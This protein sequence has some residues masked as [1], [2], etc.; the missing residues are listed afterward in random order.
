M[1]YGKVISANDEVVVIPKIRKDQ[2]RKCQ[3]IVRANSKFPDIAVGLLRDYLKENPELL[4]IT[5]NK[6]TDTINVT[7]VHQFSRMKTVYTFKLTAP[8][9]LETPTL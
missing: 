3:T 6:E 4:A 9:L 7:L 2:Q 8:V 5:H 1:S